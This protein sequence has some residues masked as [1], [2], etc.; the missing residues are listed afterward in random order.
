MNNLKNFYYF[1]DSFQSSDFSEEIAQD[2]HILFSAENGVKHT[3]YKNNFEQFTLV[4]DQQPSFLKNGNESFQDN[5]ADDDILKLNSENKFKNKQANK[6]HSESV[7]KEKNLVRMGSSLLE[8]GTPEYEKRRRSNNEAV[9]RSRNKWIQKHNEKE[10]RMKELEDENE[11]LRSLVLSLK[12]ELNE[13]IKKSNKMEKGNENQEFEVQNCT[14]IF[15]DSILSADGIDLTNDFLFDNQ[16]NKGATNTAME[17]QELEKAFTE[18]VNQDTSNHISV[19][20][21]ENASQKE[22]NLNLDLKQ[23]KGSNLN[24]IF[25]HRADQFEIQTLHAE[26]L[27]INPKNVDAHYNSR[28]YENQIKTKEAIQSDK[29]NF[30]IDQVNLPENLIGIENNDFL[31]FDLDQVNIEDLF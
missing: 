13:I 11:N 28:N 25:E 22:E 15:N 3:C 5:K 16:S 30:F 7:K 10:H 20:V 29:T 6:F 21:F 18:T 12:K 14:S 23:L 19:P 2:G 17:I 4:I 8:K 9:K 31:P 27:S 1:S 24:K 26:F